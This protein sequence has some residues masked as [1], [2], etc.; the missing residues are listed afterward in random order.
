MIHGAD[1]FPEQWI[2]S[3]EILEED[4]RLMKR[5]GCN[6]VSV[7]MF[8]WSALEPE[9]GRYTFEW[10]DALMDRAAREGIVVLLA[11]P[12][13]ARPAW[14]SRAYPEVLRVSPERRRNLH[15]L[16]HNHCYTSP[17]FRQK[18]AA[19]NRLIA[20]RYGDH[21]ALLM[22]HVSNEYGGE[23]HCEL[24]QRAFREW[25]RRRYGSSLDSLNLAW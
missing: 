13:G 2:D 14:M 17:V 21:P 7:G 11:T 12:S 4:M 24:C 23:C 16:R 19:V 1:Y 15:G 10:L 18:T 22:W 20:A 9:E 3:P 25:L 5:A 6:A 8:A